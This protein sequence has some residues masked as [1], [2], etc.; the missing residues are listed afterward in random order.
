V[1]GIAPARGLLRNPWLLR[2]IE[3]HCR[4]ESCAERTL[5]ERLSILADIADDADRAVDSRPGFVVEVAGHLLG[6]GSAEFAQLVGC[7][8]L[9]EATGTLRTLAAEASHR[10]AGDCT[11]PGI[12]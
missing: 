1:D 5:A 9:G 4:G 3:Q 12:R 11:D 8:T 2:D 6:R 7:R 10:S